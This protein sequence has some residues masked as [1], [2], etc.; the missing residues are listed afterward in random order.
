MKF[1]SVFILAVCCLSSVV[2]SQVAQR[3]PIEVYKFSSNVITKDKIVGAGGSSLRTEVVLNVK[4][5]SKSGDEWVRNVEVGV[6]LAY[7]DKKAGAKQ[8]IFYRSTAK[9]FALKS[10]TRVPVVFYIP[11]E[12]YGMYRIIGEPEAYKIDLSVGG[13]KIELSQKNK[14]KLLSK[15]ITSEAILK[16]F[17]EEVES[18]AS[19]NDGAMKPLN[20]CDMPIQCHELGI[21]ASLGNSNMTIPTYIQTK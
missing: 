19:Q 7:L 9:L 14:G 18:K 1:K 11:W 6:T 10:G 20:M 13:T 4:G 16:A 15:N 8:Y 12:S 21:P 2:F 3:D 5:D 17:L